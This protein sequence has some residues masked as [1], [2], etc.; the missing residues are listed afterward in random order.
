MQHLLPQRQHR[1]NACLTQL[2]H[3]LQACILHPQ[4]PHGS[5]AN[6]KKNQVRTS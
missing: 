3:S 1:N 5:S 6:L 2:S 4:A